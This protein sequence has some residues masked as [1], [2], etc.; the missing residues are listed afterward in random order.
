MSSNKG[1]I[2]WTAMNHPNICIIGTSHIT[3]GN[4]KSL[5]STHNKE[6]T[7]NIKTNLVYVNL[8][9][10]NMLYCITTEISARISMTINMC[11]LGGRSTF[12]FD[13]MENESLF[14][15]ISCLLSVF[16][17]IFA[18]S[19][20]FYLCEIKFPA[21]IYKILRLFTGHFYPVCA[22]YGYVCVVIFYITLDFDGS[23]LRSESIV[24]RPYYIYQRICVKEFLVF[25]FV[26]RNGNGRISRCR[27][28][29]HSNE[30]H[31]TMHSRQMRLKIR[32]KLTIK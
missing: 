18:C 5:T 8:I 21:W 20:A 17:Y 16:I 4:D 29:S 11:L 9:Y 19:V 15:H 1:D 12:M 30:E 14:I 2:G 10:I 3:Y 13:R 32:P 22:V 6:D 27:N 7:Q 31:M 24:S 28:T 25:D 26:G 23:L